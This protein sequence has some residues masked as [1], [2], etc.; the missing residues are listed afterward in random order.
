MPRHV[1][2][3]A[4]VQDNRVKKINTHLLPTSAHAVQ[5]YRVSGGT[6][7]DNSPFGHDPLAM[8]PRKMQIR[9][10]AFKGRY[11]S[12][13]VLFHNIANSNPTPF[14]DALKFY[15]DVTFRLSRS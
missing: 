8:D 14:R 11:P 13:E 4:M 3:K 9:D 6:I 10:E 15:I 7:S 5:Q 1:P 2:D 12:F